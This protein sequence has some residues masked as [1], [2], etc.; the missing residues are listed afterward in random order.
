[1][2]L[3]LPE[4][5]VDVDHVW[6]EVAVEVLGVSVAVEVGGQGAASHGVGERVLGWGLEHIAKTIPLVRKP[7]ER[8]GSPS[9]LSCGLEVAFFKIPLAGAGATLGGPPLP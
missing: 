8:T 6:L 5:L 3:V 7:L 9:L 1:M 4:V 2:L